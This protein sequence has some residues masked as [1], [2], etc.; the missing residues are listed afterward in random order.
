MSKLKE[1]VSNKLWK[2][3]R[4]DYAEL[5]LE[6]VYAG[7]LE[8]PFDKLPPEG[9]LQNLGRKSVEPTISLALECEASVFDNDIQPQQPTLT[10]RGSISL[11]IAR[12]Q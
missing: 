12:L 1:Y 5:L 10:R 2:K 7:K 11:A 8:Y 3:S 6:Q 4:N 9:D